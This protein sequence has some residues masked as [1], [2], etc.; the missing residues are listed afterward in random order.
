MAKL[1]VYVEEIKHTRAM[2]DE[3]WVDRWVKGADRDSIYVNRQGWV[4]FLEA[5]MLAEI[6]RLLDNKEAA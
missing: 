2:T 1:R 6:T 5:S 3:E 4:A